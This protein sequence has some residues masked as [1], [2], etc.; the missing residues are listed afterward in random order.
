MLDSLANQNIA[1]WHTAASLIASSHR[2]AMRLQRID[3]NAVIFNAIFASQL[4][5]VNGRSLRHDDFSKKNNWSDDL[6]NLNE[7]ACRFCV[8]GAQHSTCTEISLWPDLN[9]SSLRDF[10]SSDSGYGGS[11]YP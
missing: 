11:M 1:V 4:F 9:E 8:G 3:S 7:V 2:S 5:S 6:N 10:S